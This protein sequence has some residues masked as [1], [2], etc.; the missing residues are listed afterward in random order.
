VSA[1]V[2]APLPLSAPS[3]QPLSASIFFGG[4]QHV[5]A[6]F[7]ACVSVNNDDDVDV[8]VVRF[9]RDGG[10]DANGPRLSVVFVVFVVVVLVFVISRL[11]YFT[12][13]LSNRRR[14]R[15]QLPP[16]STSLAECLGFSIERWYSL[17][18]EGCPFIRL[19]MHLPIVVRDK[20]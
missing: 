5:D 11:D 3:N 13:P 19:S 12:R 18:K 15:S 20:Q 16:L 17:V 4:A 1:S 2:F 9:L 6:S 7:G 10:M 14:G 8:D